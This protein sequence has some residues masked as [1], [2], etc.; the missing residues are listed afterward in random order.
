[1]FKLLAFIKFNLI[2]YKSLQFYQNYFTTIENIQLKKTSS[3]LKIQLI[4]LASTILQFHTVYFY[5]FPSNNAFDIFLHYDALYFIIPLNGRQVLI[6]FNVLN[7]IYFYKILY[8]KFCLKFTNISHEIL[9]LN[10]SNFLK[11]N[12]LINRNEFVNIQRFAFVVLNFTQIYTAGLGK[13]LFSETHQL[14]C[15]FNRCIFCL[16]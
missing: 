10:K 11:S 16:Y 5:F 12:F 14:T 2:P 6:F 8:F 9:F 7:I 3:I 4:L 1:M 15:I 13:L